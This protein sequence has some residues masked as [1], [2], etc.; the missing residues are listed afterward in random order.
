[1]IIIPRIEVYQYEKII[2]KMR[3]IQS[4]KHYYQNEKKIK[5]WL[6]M[7]YIVFIKMIKRR[8]EVYQ[9]EKTRNSP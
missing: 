8:I 2:I 1:M 3:K 7:T 9:Y 4:L 6:S 5:H